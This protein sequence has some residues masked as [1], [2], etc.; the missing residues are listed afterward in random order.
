MSITDFFSSFRSFP[1]EAVPGLNV[2]DQSRKNIFRQKQNNIPLEQNAPKAPTEN[3]IMEKKKYR[4]KI[5][6]LAVWFQYLVQKSYAVS[7][8]ARLVGVLF[9]SRLTVWFQY[10]V[11]K[12]YAVFMAARLVGVLFQSRLTVWLRS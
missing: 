9:Q 4:L 7:I 11:Q 2:S 1:L 12:S 3:V 5:M 10:L 6:R 8:P